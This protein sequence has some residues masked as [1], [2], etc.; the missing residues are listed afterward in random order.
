MSLSR[1]QHAAAVA[2]HQNDVASTS[3]ELSLNPVLASSP[4]MSPL[5]PHDAST[6][7]LGDSQKDIA[8]RRHAQI[9]KLDGQQSLSPANLRQLFRLMDIDNSQ[10]LSFSELKSGLAAMK[11]FADFTSSAS[12]VNQLLEEVDTDRSGIITEQEFVDFFQRLQR[13]DLAKKLKDYQ[14]KGTSDIHISAI[15]FTGKG[16][17]GIVDDRREGLALKDL[18]E[19]L[20]NFVQSEKAELLDYHVWLDV[21]GFDE[22]ML[23]LLSNVMGLHAESLSDPFIVQRQKVD[24]FA[25]QHSASMSLGSPSPAGQHRPVATTSSFL[26]EEAVA[27]V[28]SGAEKALAK[29]AASDRDA[30]ATIQAE[31]PQDDIRVQFLLHAMSMAN[32]P[33]SGKSITGRAASKIQKLCGCCSSQYG[34]SADTIK[35]RDA[36]VASAQKLAKL[37]EGDT[38][39]A[40]GPDDE[41]EVSEDTHPC[42][43]AARPISASR[44]PV[45]TTASRLRTH[46]PDIALEQFSMFVV[47]NRTLLTLRSPSV[48]AGGRT[49]KAD[50]SKRPLAA[51]DAKKWTRDHSVIGILF[52]GLRRRI[53]Q[54][55]AANYLYTSSVRALACDILDAVTQFN[56]GIRDALTGT[57]AACLFDVAVPCDA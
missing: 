44:K 53:R 12:V 8:A 27:A 33:F 55:G 57:R 28:V 31:A 42:L 1:E 19:F 36:A 15:V 49:Y 22:N 37:F 10:N 54:A 5:S 38:V 9:K 50:K 21:V 52:R 45:L 14:N 43:C 7:R 13:H 26:A 29:R 23:T 2:M 47:N 11:I 56:F 4:P 41:E 16:G 20:A 24:V 39:D 17:L 6:V 46:P 51:D 3:I 34:D 18:P 48:S 32:P 25:A 35:G 30:S 40:V